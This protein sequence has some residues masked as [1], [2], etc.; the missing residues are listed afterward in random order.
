MSMNSLKKLSIRKKILFSMIGFSVIPVLIVTIIALNNTYKNMRDQLIFNRRM[1]IRWLQDRL[2][3]ETQNYTG[4]FYKF[5]ANTEL[6]SDIFRWSLTGEEPDYAA[7][8][9]LISAM[10]VAISMDSNINSIDIYN[11]SNDTV[12]IA[13]RSG[14][15]LTQTGDRLE[16]WKKRDPS[17]QTNIVFMRTQREILLAH[18]MTRFEDNKPIALV[19]IHLRPYEIQDIIRD[20]R[21]T[22]DESV[23]IFND[24]DELIEAA[25]GTGE[26]FSNDYLL[27]VL[28]SLRSSDTGET[29]QDGYFWFYR[30]VNGGKIQ[31]LSSVPNRNIVSTLSKTLIGGLMAAVISLIASVLCS[32]L[33][34]NIISK[35]IIDLSSKMRTT[36]L[37]GSA[38]SIP[39]SRQDEIGVLQ[40]SFGEMIA[41]N[42]LL[43]A[44]EYRSKIEKRD[45][46][47]SA[48][49]AQINPHFLNNTLQAIGGIALKKQAPEIYNITVALSD[50][51][52]Y[53][54]NFSKEM[55]R[56]KEEIHYLYSYLTIQ[57]QRFGN[58]IEFSAEV[59]EEAENCLI[60]KLIL[61]PLLENSFEHGLINR[62]GSWKIKMTGEVTPNGDLLLTVEDNGLGI[63]PEK[64]AQI[65]ERLSSDAENALGAG[66][67]I[68]LC[69][70]DSRIRLK[71]PG[72]NYGVSIDST[73][74]QGT[75]VKVLMKAVREV[76][77][78]NGI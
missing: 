23:I 52:R 73:E 62:S 12:L 78:S 18:Q 66:A 24:Q 50:I 28:D 77:K 9:R 6:K 70:V 22:D 41:R 58:R 67:H 51:M 39:V 29:I 76:A 72:E 14:A 3:T 64:L 15:S 35:P 20:I 68:G 13:A 36:L 1:S 45:A 57:N 42:Q 26:E 30:P 37:D 55:V 4:Q 31:I 8:L 69:N 7:K 71:Y 60:P 63:S 19:V 48:L 40:K 75:V 17:L 38:V 2:D 11:L 27:S 16:E 47:I 44:Q 33:F 46:Q 5:E 25:Y 43:V 56:L 10:N 59:T 32:V 21:M 61:Q 34:S 49:Q 65:R 53:S 74:G 54:L